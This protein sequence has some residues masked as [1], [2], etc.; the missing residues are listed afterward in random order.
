M[1]CEL[2]AASWSQEAYGLAW[3]TVCF[4]LIFGLLAAAVTLAKRYREHKSLWKRLNDRSAEDIDD[5]GQLLTKFRDL[6]SRGTLSDVE[7]RSIKSKLA[8]QIHGGLTPG[9]GLQPK[10]A[11]PLAAD[12][13]GQNNSDEL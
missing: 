9:E 8:A 6:H 7:Y 4:A 12:G 5:P 13:D 11:K 1:H 2:L 3:A 10:P